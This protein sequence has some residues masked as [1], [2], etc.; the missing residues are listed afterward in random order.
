MLDMVQLHGNEPVEAAGWLSGLG[1]SVIRA[2]HVPPVSNA[3]PNGTAN[4]SSVSPIITTDSQEVNP[5]AAKRLS[6]DEMQPIRA[7]GYHHHILLDSMRSDG[8]S[9]GTGKV[10]DWDYARAIVE[11]GEVPRNKF[12]NSSTSAANTSEIADENNTTAYSSLPIILAG[13]LTPEN[14]AEAVEKVRPWAVDVSSGVE[15]SDGTG[16]DHGKIR[17][18]IRA[19][20]GFD[21]ED[22]RGSVSGLGI[23]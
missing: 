2:I 5:T 11:A 20:K 13:G 10:A 19:A 14:V 16:K 12:I 17:A 21:K 23:A 18:F 6:D 1:V 7:T 22:R 8:M 9:G 4:D 15:A 3:I